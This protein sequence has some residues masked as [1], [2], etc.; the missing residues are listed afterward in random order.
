LKPAGAKSF[1]DLILISEHSG[2]CLSF[3]ATWEAEFG[4]IVVPA[5]P[6]P[7]KKICETPSQRKK[8]GVVAHLSS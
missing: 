3:L 8:A 7:P 4:R 5:H 1:R 6:P 2:T